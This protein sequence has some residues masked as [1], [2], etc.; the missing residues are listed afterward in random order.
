KVHLLEA[1]MITT[2]QD[3]LEQYLNS[4]VPELKEGSPSSVTDAGL[5]ESSSQGV[6]PA[7]ELMKR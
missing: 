4:Q 1:P 5:L 7:R 2:H 3:P 6:L